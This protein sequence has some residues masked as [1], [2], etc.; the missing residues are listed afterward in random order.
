GR[1]R[2]SGELGRAEAKEKEGQAVPKNAGAQG[3]QL[4]AAAEVEGDQVH[5]RCLLTAPTPGSR[6]ELQ[7]VAQQTGPR[8]AEDRS[9][10]VHGRTYPGQLPHVPVDAEPQPSLGSGNGRGQTLEPRSPVPHQAWKARQTESGGGHRGE[11]RAS[12]GPGPEPGFGG[13]LP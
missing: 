13:A 10:M 9:E 3:P 7:T 5:V 11:R 8:P 4:L 2:E 12:V 1:G 6:N